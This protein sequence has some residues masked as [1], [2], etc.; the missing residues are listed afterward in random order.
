VG[1]A[2]PRGPFLARMRRMVSLLALARVAE[3]G[4]AEVRTAG[5][6]LLRAMESVRD[7]SPA[8]CGRI[9]AGAD[10]LLVQALVPA[11][12][13]APSPV[14]A[15]LD[16]AAP[17]AGTT[18]PVPGAL[19]T[20]DRVSWTGVPPSEGSCAEEAAFYR[21]ALDGGTAG[22]LRL[23]G[24]FRAIVAAPRTEASAEPQ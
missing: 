9:G 12:A 3:A 7:R 1:E 2:R 21:E 20:G 19:G 8:L 4:D 14:E 5:G 11:P 17:P 22:L 23:R 16:A 15:L 6:L 13:G 24:R 10:L 18:L